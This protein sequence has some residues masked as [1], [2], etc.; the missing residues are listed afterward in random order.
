MCVWEGKIDSESLKNNKDV[1]GVSFAS[2][3]FALVHA[4]LQLVLQFQL[5]LA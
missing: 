2:C 4:L 5:G 3:N 1:N